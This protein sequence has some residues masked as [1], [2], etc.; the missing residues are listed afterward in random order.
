MISPVPPVQL[1]RVSEREPTKEVDTSAQASN[2]NSAQNPNQP[3]PAPQETEHQAPSQK[4]YPV[5]EYQDNA[6]PSNQNQRFRTNQNKPRSQA[7][8]PA[9]RDEAHISKSTHQASAHG[10]RN[11]PPE[12]NLSSSVL[13][14][15]PGPFTAERFLNSD[16]RG[17]P[18][19]ARSIYYFIVK[20]LRTL[21]EVL[22][23]T[24]FLRN[25]KKMTFS[26]NA[27]TRPVS[28]NI[29]RG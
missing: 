13:G 15:G 7:P 22:E 28:I 11:S 14:N 9:Q 10:G 24:D 21:T 8:K 26:D 12:F 25:D 4:D 2:Q 1:Q 27:S 18:S 19:E 17:P 23:G 16:S 20:G 29:S 3:V 5:E 6:E